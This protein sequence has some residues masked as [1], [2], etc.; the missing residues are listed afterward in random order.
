[1]G[2]KLPNPSPLQPQFP[3]THTRATQYVSPFLFLPLSH[4]TGKEYQQYPAFDE[5]ALQ[6]GS[7][8]VFSVL[9]G[10]A[11]PAAKKGTTDGTSY[12]HYSQMATVESNWALGNL[13]L[14]DATASK[15]F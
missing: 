2:P 8:K 3:E 5:T 15:F 7:N 13:G 11:V 14:G 4:K 1:M 12:N 9:L 10:D 6:I